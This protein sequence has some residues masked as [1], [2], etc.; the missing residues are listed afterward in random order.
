MRRPQ[1]AGK[2]FEL[3]GEQLQRRLRRGLARVRT[4]LCRVQA[5]PVSPQSAP[6]LQ[7]VAHLQAVFASDPCPTAAFQ[8]RFQ[9]PLLVEPPIPKPAADHNETERNESE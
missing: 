5:P 4:Q 1:C 8:L 3:G 9:R 2:P 6:L 7:T